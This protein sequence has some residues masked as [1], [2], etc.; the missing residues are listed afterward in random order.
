MNN[1]KN[2]NESIRNLESVLELNEKNIDPV[3]L[4]KLEEIFCSIDHNF[5]NVEDDFK[6]INEKLADNEGEL[7]KRK[8]IIWNNKDLR[9]DIILSAISN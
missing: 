1:L 3:I 4:E 6:L 8:E 9:R 7:N 2:L 5:M